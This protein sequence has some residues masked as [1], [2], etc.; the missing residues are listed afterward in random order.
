MESEEARKKSQTCEN[1]CRAAERWGRV[2]AKECVFV[3]VF[4]FVNAGM[5]GQWWHAG[6]N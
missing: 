1:M 6:K 2:C 4:V 3:C 5:G